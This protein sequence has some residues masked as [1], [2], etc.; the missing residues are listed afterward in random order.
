[1]IQDKAG[2]AM[3]AMSQ[4]IVH[5]CFYVL[6]ALVVS[7][8]AATDGEDARDPVELHREA[9]NARE[10]GDDTAALE[11]YRALLEIEPER[12]QAWFE[13]GKLAAS[14]DRLDEAQRAFE[15]ALEYDSEF[16]KARHNL[17]LVHMRKGAEML[18][19]SREDMDDTQATRST[20]IYL[21]C[22]LAQTVEHPELDIPC[23]DLP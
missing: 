14:A 21:S 11:A 7:G 4:R 17:G 12:P 8:C 6:I 22:L 15:K 3:P 2:F 20:D 23:P 9:L 16:V 13:R 18:Q 19:A 5:G 10:R 1:M